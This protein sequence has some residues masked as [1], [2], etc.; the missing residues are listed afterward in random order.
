MVN[1]E[2]ASNTKWGTSKKAEFRDS[3]ANTMLIRVFPQ[4]KRRKGTVSLSKNIKYKMDPHAGKP[5]RH[6]IPVAIREL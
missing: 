4:K 2:F 3:V 1:D 6:A 5:L